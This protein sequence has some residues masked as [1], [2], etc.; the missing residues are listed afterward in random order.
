MHTR[1]CRFASVNAVQNRNRRDDA[2]KRLARSRKKASAMDDMA[3]T[4]VK[5]I[6]AKA[7]SVDLPI[8]PAKSIK[9]KA[10]RKPGKKD[11]DILEAAPA[12]PAET[13]PATGARN[14][15]EDLIND[16]PSAPSNMP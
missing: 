9:K 2:Q 12:V 16:K 6:S 4:P 7:E 5:E 3:E 15:M 11:A 10:K 1:F 8:T 13:E 14:M